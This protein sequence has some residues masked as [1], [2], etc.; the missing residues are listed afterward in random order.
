MLVPHRLS[1]VPAADWTLV[2]EDGSITADGDD[3]APRARG[4]C[5]AERFG[6]QAEGYRGA[7]S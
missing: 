6:L 5:Y 2:L 4:G 3:D 7:T 1:S